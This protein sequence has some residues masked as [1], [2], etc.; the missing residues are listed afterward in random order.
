LGQTK[1]SIPLEEDTLLFGSEGV[2]SILEWL[3]RAP[4]EQNY[5]AIKRALRRREFKLPEKWREG[6]PHDLDSILF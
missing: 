6:P 2:E 5:K 4:D 3:N 1:C